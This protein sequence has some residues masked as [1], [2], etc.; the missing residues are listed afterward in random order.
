MFNN[1]DIIIKAI[2]IGLLLCL[3][4]DYSRLREQN[5]KLHKDVEGLGVAIN[6]VMDTTRNSI[7]QMKAQ[8]GTVVLSR[9]ASMKYLSEDIKKLK[10]EFKFRIND[11]KSYVQVSG[12]YRIPV[13]IEGKDTIIYKSTEKVYYMGGRYKGKLYTK[14]DSLLGSISIDDT[15]RITTSKGKR[16]SW[17]KIW[18]KRPLV[19]NAFMSNP[20]GSVTSLKSVLTD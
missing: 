6:N 9:D 15:I 16:D 4:M 5:N 20:D 8:V 13:V 1:I 14:G 19:T 11:L 3:V 18:K 2:I 10:D 17:W 7:G 12:E